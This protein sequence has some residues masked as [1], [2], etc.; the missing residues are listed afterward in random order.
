MYK[1]NLWRLAGERR[2]KVANSRTV[3]LYTPLILQKAITPTAMRQ[4]QNSI[5]IKSTAYYNCI[6]C[7]PLIALGCSNTAWQ[8]KYA[9]AVIHLLPY[10]KVQLQN[11]SRNFM[12][13][14]Q[15]TEC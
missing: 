2:R 9:E 4:V 5:F 12:Y 7:L 1:T 6:L 11:S 13:Q 3:L 14:F 10:E 8:K 15:Q